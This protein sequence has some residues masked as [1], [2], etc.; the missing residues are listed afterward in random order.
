MD[1]AHKLNV[2]GL[3]GPLTDCQDRK[4]A[5]QKCH[6]DEQIEGNVK[7]LPAP[8]EGRAQCVWV[9]GKIEPLVMTIQIH[10]Q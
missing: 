7:S 1:T 5:G 3:D 2:L 6:G 4:R 8:G 9:V 10:G